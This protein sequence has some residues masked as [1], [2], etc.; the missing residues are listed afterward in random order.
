MT[1]C[2]MINSLF[3]KVAFTKRSI[4]PFLNEIFT[5]WPGKSIAPIHYIFQSSMMIFP[6]IYNS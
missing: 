2:L 4:A 6:D 1:L 5:G 3:V